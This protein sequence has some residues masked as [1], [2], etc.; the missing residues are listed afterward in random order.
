MR[1]F[2]F[3]PDEL[4]KAVYQCQEAEKTY[5]QAK[6]NYDI[7]EDSA[8][9]VLAQIKNKIRTLSDTSDAHAEAQGRASQEWK[10][11]KMGLYGAK[12]ALGQASIDY[13][14]AKRVVDTLV[15]GMA[16]KRELLKKGIV[17]Q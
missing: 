12:R 4:I 11:F 13:N 3:H 1:K 17:D 6:V 5:Q 8:K 7:L 14:H 16:Y 10:E 9:D 2:L 15:S